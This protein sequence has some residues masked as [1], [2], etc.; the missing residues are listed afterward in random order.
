MTEKEGRVAP[1]HPGPHVRHNV[2]PEGMTVTKAAELLGVGRPALSNFLNGKAALSPEMA[3]R[4]ERTFGANGNLLLDMQ[5]QISRPKQAARRPVVTGTHAPTLV[6]IKAKDIARWAGEKDAR[7]AL[8]AL[9]R[10]LVHSTGHDLIHV[11]FPAFENAERPGWDG[12]VEVGTPTPWIPQGKSRWEFGCDARPKRKA[13]SDYAKRTKAV[14]VAERRE[15]TFVFVTP[16]NWSSKKAWEKEKGGL[17]EWN[18][19]RTLDAN[20]L[21]QWIEQSPKVQ[22]WFA[23]R[24]GWQIAD[25]SSLD[26]CWSDWA[27]TCDPPISEKLFAPAVKACREKF[28]QWLD[29]PPERPFIVAA[30]S[31]GEALAFL[32]CL[33]DEPGSGAMPTRANAVV[34]DTPEAAKRFNATGGAG[35]LAIFPGS[36][37]QRET[38]SLHQRSHCVMVRPRNDVHAEPDISLGLLGSEDFSAALRAMKLSEGRIDRLAR[39][40]AR[41]PTVLQRRLSANPA[42]RAPAW[43]EDP[44]TARKLLPAAFAGA[45]HNASA[46]DREVVRLL[47]N[48]REYSSTEA[49]VAALQALEDPPLWSAGA[50]RG[51]VSRIDALFGVAKFVTKP[52]LDNFFFVAECI[53]SESDPALDLPEEKRWMVAV[54]GKVRDHSDAL[55]RGVR[56]TLILLAVFGNDLF[57]HILGFDAEARVA[58]LVRKLLTPLDK[59]ELLSQND[60]LPDYAEAAPGDFLSLIEGDLRQDN[61][62]VQALL[63]PAGDVL[64]GSP[65]RTDLLWALEGVAWDPQYFPRVVEVLAQ[66]CRRTRS[67]SED[68]WANKPEATLYSLFRAWKPNTAASLED[69]IRTFEKLCCDYP[70]LGWSICIRHMD[71]GPDM[72][73]PNGIWRWR[74]DASTRGRKITNEEF[75]SFIRKAADLALAW[76]NHSEKTLSDLFERM[77]GLAHQD[78]IEI[79]ELIERWIDAEPTENEKESLRKTIRR[80][81]YL[82]HLRK[83]K[84]A[85]PKRERNILEKLVLQDLIL[86]HA[87]LF[88]AHWIDLPPEDGDEEAFDRERNEARL[89]ELRC[90]AV[91]EIWDNHGSAGIDRLLQGGRSGYLVGEQMAGILKGFREKELEFARFCIRAASSGS[92]SPFRSCLSAFIWNA[93]PGFVAALAEDT[94]RASDPEDLLTLFLAL[95]ARKATW[96]MLDSQTDALRMEYWRA[97]EPMFFRDGQE[98]ELNEAIDRLLDAGRPGAAFQSA[99]LWWK[100][101]ETSRIRKILGGL[102]NAGP[103]DHLENDHF[104]YDLSE[105]LE[106]LDQRPGVPAEEKVRLEYAYLPLL[107][108]SRHGIPNLEREICKSPEVYA[109]AVCYLYKGA[110]GNE[111][112]EEPNLFG[113]MGREPTTRHIFELL[114]SVSRL[115][116][117]GED[118][119]VDSKALREW[120]ARVRDLCGRRSRA[121]MGDIKIGELLARAGGKEGETWPSRPVCEAL[122]WLVSED[123]DRGFCIGARKRRGVHSRAPGEGGRQ[124][125]D[126]AARYRGWADALRHEFPHVGGV[127][128]DI[129]AS[130]GSDAGWQDNRAEVRLR[131]PDM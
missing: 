103:S 95:P 70:E 88:A 90:S 92:E 10:Q 101:V 73:L 130:Y 114:N 51:V 97:V 43:A 113:P 27:S 123:M 86:R 42:N 126:L 80:C 108:R 21:E 117:T 124:E 46:A 40:S 112:Q 31:R 26:R 71:L 96:R 116:G 17:D 81:A 41:S 120:I 62:T 111:D 85:F 59:E 20:D 1:G 49:D 79:F 15:M 12:E 6:A 57:Q 23:E 94:G 60:N 47:A 75:S 82:R 5:A 121:D 104:D 83:E 99:R 48:D 91:R 106:N 35:Q 109:D 7:D 66:L 4:L 69:R 24:I 25:Y 128:D 127:L 32:H 39:E 118:G 77:E 54:Y 28:A 89:R 55:R 30:D 37:T 125:R 93:E 2:I 34:F 87:W 102:I 50:Y 14:P 64:T 74:S 76:P 44:E 98:D 52:D 38:G 61:P 53:L 110:D 29:R 13:D 16:R 119:T 115:P 22:V 122:E 68:N 131:L 78:Q 19:V 58:G 84:A 72:A 9:L 18:E 65:L 105:G 107:V 100:G 129:A 45:W 3:L 8:A 63:R 33:V 67:E 11:D 36:E 56:E